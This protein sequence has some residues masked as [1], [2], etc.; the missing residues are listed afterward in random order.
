MAVTIKAVAEAAGVSIT[1]VSFVLNNKHPQVDAI[2]KATRDRVKACAEALGYRRNPA[3]AALRTGRSLWVGV[4]MQQLRDESDAWMWAPFELS[5]LSGVQKTLSERGYYAV[6]GSRPYGL[7]GDFASVEALISSGI[8]GLILRCPSSE[9]VQRISE[10][11]KDAV[12]TIAVF[13]LNR[14]DL[15]PYIIDVDNFRAGELAADLF[16]RAGREA[17]MLVLNEDCRHVETDRVNGFS[18]VV[19]RKLGFSPT[20]CRI[21]NAYSDVARV[22][23]MTDFLRANKPDCVMTTEAGNAFLM[24]FAA[25]GLNVKVP[26]E[27]A[28]IG[29]DCYSFRS[30][31]EQRISAVGT[32]WW[33]AGQLA[34][35]SILD[36]IEN[37][38]K[39]TEPKMLEPRFIPGDTTPPELAEHSDLYW[40]L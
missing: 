23:A 36:M 28:I 17:P 33:Q 26:D 21:P 16:I 10:A 13:P 1:T 25:E 24:S 30:A 12:P 2:P 38:T 8:G 31:R 9:T 6:L 19:E 14:D 22:V 27:L 18:A 7:K 32:S 39:W 20:I 29:F 34:A 4:I 37:N 3:A 5:L 35:S 11:G 15:Y 40:L